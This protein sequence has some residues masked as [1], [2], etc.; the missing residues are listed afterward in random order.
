[1]PKVVTKIFILLLVAVVLY[2]LVETM[3]V[4]PYKPQQVLKTVPVSGGQPMLP[5]KTLTIGKNS[6][7]AE[8]ASTTQQ[9]SDGLS[10]RYGLQEG[11][12][13]LFVFDT[14]LI[15]GFWM[16]DMR[17]SLDILY[18]DSTG[19]IVTLFENL[20]PDTYPKAFRPTVPAQYVLELP[21]GYVAAHSIA[22]GDKIVL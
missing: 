7:L 2:G 10:G 22:V 16:K 3:R 12:G 18:A 11:T 6:V 9:K 21:A 4:T 1:M 13:M 14:P 17:F 8:V 15:E 20:S 5:T 19:K